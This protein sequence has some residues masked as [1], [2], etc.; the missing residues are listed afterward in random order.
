MC[1]DVDP[2]TGNGVCTPHCVGSPDAPSCDD[3]NRVC[4]INGDG[5]LTLC[6]PTCDPLTDTCD[7]GQGCY[8][9][10]LVFFC[11]PDASGKGGGPFES[12]EFVNG[13]DPGTVCVPGDA[14]TACDSGACCSPYCNLEAPDCPDPMVC[15]PWYEEGTLPPGGGANIGY[16][17]DADWDGG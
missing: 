15:F 12:C 8:P 3:P 16:C 10:D 17:A 13:C 11:A 14:A 5:V 2:E 7:D 4:S 9:F 6:L 1:W